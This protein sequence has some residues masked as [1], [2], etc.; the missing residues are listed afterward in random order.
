MP[1]PIQ[2]SLTSSEVCREL[3]IDRSTLSRW[4]AAGRIEPMTKLPGI[5]GAF[6][7]HRAEVVRVLRERDQQA[8]S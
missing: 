7:F 4:V 2:E 8:A 5:R 1:T 3:S 6:L